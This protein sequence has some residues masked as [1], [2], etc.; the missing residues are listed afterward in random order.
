MRDAVKMESIQRRATKTIKDIFFK[1]M[2][3]EL[4]VDYGETSVSGYLV[5]VTRISE[6]RA[7]YKWN[8]LF[9]WH[10]ALKKAVDSPTSVHSHMVLLGGNR[11]IGTLLS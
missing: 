5:T 7:E 2:L 8:L 1:G 3:K 10:H 11:F 6:R 9:V 4:D